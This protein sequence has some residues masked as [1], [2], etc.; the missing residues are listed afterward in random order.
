MVHHVPRFLSSRRS[1]G[2][3]KIALLVFD[4]LAV[5]QWVRIRER[6]IK[7]TSTLEFEESTCFAWLPTLTS[8][9][10]QALFSGL[11]PREFSES[12]ETTARESVQW[13]SFWKDHG[14]R[15]NEVFYRKGIKRTDQLAELS[16]EISNPAI[17]IAGLV[18]DTVDEIIHGTGLGLAVARKTVEEHKGVIWVESNPNEGASFFVKIPLGIPVKG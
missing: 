8:V 9:S 3:D 6:L 11:K 17:K 18:I 16:S 10:R 4:G 5:D 7:K 13:L 1:S 2:E 15:Q 14:L 12:I